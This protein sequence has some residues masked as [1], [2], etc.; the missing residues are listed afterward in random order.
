MPSALER[1]V[2]RAPSPY[3]TIRV[4][5][6]PHLATP[7]YCRLELRYC[8]ELIRS[9]EKNVNLWLWPAKAFRLYSDTQVPCFEKHE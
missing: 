1:S 6:S 7:L 2:S 9:G 3:Y 4:A 8:P 5:S